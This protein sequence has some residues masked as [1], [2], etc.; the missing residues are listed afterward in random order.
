MG[1]PV[2]VSISLSISLPLDFRLVGYTFWVQ[3]S[4]V[5]F[6]FFF[7]VCVSFYL[8]FKLFIVFWGVANEQ[9]CDSLR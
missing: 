9:C 8:L 6:F 5:D 2:L 3:E 1:E 4:Y 7:F